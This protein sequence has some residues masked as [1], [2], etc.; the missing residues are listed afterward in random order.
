M[1]I[2]DAAPLVAALLGEPG[3]IVSG[4]MLADPRATRSVR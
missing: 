1:A 3:G 4:R 2:F